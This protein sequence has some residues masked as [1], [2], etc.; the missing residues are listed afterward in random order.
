M[1]HTLLL[2]LL[3]MIIWQTV[4]ATIFLVERQ[5]E[6]ITAFVGLG[7][8]LP[9][10]L[11]LSVIVRQSKLYYFRHFTKCYRIC[12]KTG[13]FCNHSV[14]ISNRLAKKFNVKE[15]PEPYSIVEENVDIKSIPSKNFMITRKNVKHGHPGFSKE[16]LQKCMK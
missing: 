5:D 3:G 4:S 13:K 16:L 12:G 7:L 2:V 10:L 14:L 1:I 8:W 15:K 9:I 6:E 11:I